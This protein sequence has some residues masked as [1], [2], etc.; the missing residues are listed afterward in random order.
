[1]VN[2]KIIKPA[3]AAK[4]IEVRGRY[5]AS[6]QQTDIYKIGTVSK[7]DDKGV[8]IEYEYEWNMDP[9]PGTPEYKPIE[10]HDVIKIMDGEL[11]GGFEF[12][13]VKRLKGGS[14][15]RITRKSKGVSHKKT[16]NVINGW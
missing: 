5:L 4:N 10:G 7:I 15:K 13:K 6:R 8:H 3:V 14:R 1:M 11:A 9:T 12:F 16:R 2:F